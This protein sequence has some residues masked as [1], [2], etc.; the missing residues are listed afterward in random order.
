MIE[1][2]K[3][4][5]PKPWP[6]PPIKSVGSGKNDPLG[7]TL[8]EKC[9]QAYTIYMG[10]LSRGNFILIGDPSVIKV[11]ILICKDELEREWLIATN[12]KRGV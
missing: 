11:P 10:E 1:L 12:G 3:I 4:F 9:K 8:A 7:R 2:P 6:P 5:S